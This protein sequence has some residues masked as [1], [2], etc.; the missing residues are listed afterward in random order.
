MV[1]YSYDIQMFGKKKDYKFTILYKR[2]KVL[3]SEDKKKLLKEQDPKKNIITTI[4]NIKIISIDKE[5]ISEIIYITNDNMAGKNSRIKKHKKIYLT[6]NNLINED[7][8]ETANL[9]FKIENKKKIDDKNDTPNTD[10][11]SD[12]DE[13]IYFL[14][15]DK[16]AIVFRYNNIN[17]SYNIKEK[18]VNIITKL[19]DLLKT[20]RISTARNN[21]YDNS[22]YILTLVNDDNDDENRIN[23]NSKSDDDDDD[24]ESK[25]DEKINKK[26]ISHNILN[27]CKNMNLDIGKIINKIKSLKSYNLYILILVSINLGFFLVNTI[28]QIYKL[29]L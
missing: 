3:I 22:K 17:Y 6:E 1:N 9:E 21:K 13:K 16:N 15:V 26:I 8:I 29:F 24:N 27:S 2:T 11:I 4:N 20:K 25:K 10:D 23:D 18:K 14:S 12:T 7:D 28:I 19:D 5:N